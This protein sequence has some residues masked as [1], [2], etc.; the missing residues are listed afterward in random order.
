MKKLVNVLA[1]L[2]LASCFSL[3]LVACG[4]D[5]DT[6]APGPTAGAGGQ[7]S[8]GGTAVAGGGTSAGRSGGGR[9]GS[10]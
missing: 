5:D 2:A 6:A 8:T 10:N 7:T 9:G 4:D 1:V 3:S